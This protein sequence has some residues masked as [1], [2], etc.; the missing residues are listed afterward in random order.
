MNYLSHLF[1]SQRT[2]MS[3]TGNLM[4]DFKPDS[5]LK[6]RLPEQVRLGINNHR[7]VDKL[8]DEFIAV[9]NLRPLFSDKRRRF[10]GVITDITFDYFLIKHWGEFAKLERQA[11][12]KDCYAGLNQ[13][14]EYMPPRMQYVVTNMHKHDWLN[15]YATL[16]GIAITLDQ[17]S[18][19]IRFK[20]QMAGAIEEVAQHYEQIEVVFMDLFRHLQTQV[21]D[22]AIETPAKPLINN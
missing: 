12:V 7:L 4:G 5:D 13:S 17:V 11:F 8:T 22:A 2:P 3:F 14:L 18:K 19:R 20:N 16:D 21:M 1:F 15:S 6:S 10:A 9:K